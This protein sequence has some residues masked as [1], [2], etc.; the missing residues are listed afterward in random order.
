MIPANGWG[1]SSW[2]MGTKRRWSKQISSEQGDQIDFDT[3]ISRQPGS[4][5]R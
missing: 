3:H 2:R 5:N 4:L 1:T